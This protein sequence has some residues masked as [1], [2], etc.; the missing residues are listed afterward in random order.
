MYKRQYINSCLQAADKRYVCEQFPIN[1]ERKETLCYG[2][3]YV[4]ADIPQMINWQIE[5]KSSYFHLS[6]VDQAKAEFILTEMLLH[7]V[8][9]KL[10]ITCLLYTSIRKAG[11]M[12]LPTFSW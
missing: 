3:I 9:G 6:I 1:Y 10:H 7:F 2:N 12:F 5:G 11:V 8:P 4:T